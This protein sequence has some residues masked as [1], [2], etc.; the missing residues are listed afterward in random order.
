MITV[1]G[2]HNE[3]RIMTRNLVHLVTYRREMIIDKT[4]Q[5]KSNV[6]TLNLNL[7]LLQQ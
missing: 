4:N 7:N 1:F 6:V 5:N 2:K 3:N